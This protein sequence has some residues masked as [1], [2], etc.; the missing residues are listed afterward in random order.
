MSKSFNSLYNANNCDT[1]EYLEKIV[2]FTTIL[3]CN[4]SLISHFDICICANA[5]S[6][7]SAVLANTTLEELDIDTQYVISDSQYK[8]AASYGPPEII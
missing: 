3:I 4:S 2:Q 7:D 8:M 6:L 5:N 1:T